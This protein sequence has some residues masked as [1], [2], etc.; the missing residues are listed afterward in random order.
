MH[1]NILERN[2]QTC[3]IAPITSSTFAGTM[4][5]VIRFVIIFVRPPSTISK[6]LKRGRQ[7]TLQIDKRVCFRN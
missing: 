2:N 7:Q 1:K 4:Y 6:T 3:V 5:C